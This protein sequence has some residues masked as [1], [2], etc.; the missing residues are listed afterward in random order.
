[1]RK[2]YTLE[3]YQDEYQAKVVIKFLK[4]Y[5][6]CILFGKNKIRQGQKRKKVLNLLKYN[7]CG[8]SLF[9]LINCTYW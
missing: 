8:D 1:M 3:S 5:N 7:I 6:L 2:V 9:N 4:T